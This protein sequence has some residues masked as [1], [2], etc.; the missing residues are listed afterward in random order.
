MEFHERVAQL[1]HPM[2][3][4]KALLAGVQVHSDE[5]C[6]VVRILLSVTIPHPRSAESL[7]AP[8]CALLLAHLDVE[9]ALLR[10]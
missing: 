10:A 3:Q 6:C 7:S 1:A 9:D 4:M 5:L 8:G 2:R